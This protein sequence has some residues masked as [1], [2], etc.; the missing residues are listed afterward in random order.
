[1]NVTERKQSDACLQALVERSQKQPTSA[2]GRH[3]F[4]PH[5]F[6]GKEKVIFNFENYTRWGKVSN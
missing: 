6:T 2:V 3:L 4:L 1:M 5:N